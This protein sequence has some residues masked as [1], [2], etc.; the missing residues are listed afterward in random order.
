[1]EVPLLLNNNIHGSCISPIKVE[2]EKS[3]EGHLLKSK[4]IDYSFHNQSVGSN[5]NMTYDEICQVNVQ[6]N[7]FLLSYRDLS[8][9]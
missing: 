2:L 7:N 6:M 3:P 9:S 4:T 8:K 5:N 1:M